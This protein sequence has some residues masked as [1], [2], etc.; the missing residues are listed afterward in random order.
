MKRNHGWIYREPA[1]GNTPARI[2]VQFKNGDTK[3]FD[4]NSIGAAEA[5]SHITT[6][7][8]DEWKLEDLAFLGYRIVTQDPE[9]DLPSG[10][11]F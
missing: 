11:P 2:R 5:T 8:G 10:R 9:P 3:V 7:L 4:D 1:V 6:I